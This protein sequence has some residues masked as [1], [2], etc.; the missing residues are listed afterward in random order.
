MKYSVLL[1]FL[2]ACGVAQ[3]NKSAAPAKPS[4][5]QAT[6]MDP[7]Y[8]TG[9][10]H[11][12]KYGNYNY[13]QAA[14]KSALD[15]IISEIKVNVQSSTTL[16]QL[17]VNKKF[18]EQY[19]QIIKT[20][21]ADELEEFEQADAWEDQ[22]NYW[23]YIRLSK[24]RYKQ[25]KEDKKRNAVTLGLDFFT[26]ARLAEQ[27]GDIV[28]SLSYY[29]QGFRAVEKYLAEP[30]RAEYQGQEILLSNEIIRS[31][32]QMMNKI[33]ISAEPKEISV[34]RRIIKSN[35]QVTAKARERGNNKAIAGLP[36]SAV[37]E[38]GSGN[39]FPSF[40]SDENGLA[41]V[42]ITQI[43]S[44]DAEQQIAIG[45]NPNAFENNDSSAVF[46][47]IAKKLVVPKA[48]VLLHV[49]RPLVY[50]T[51]SEK[52]L[53]AEKSS[54]ELTNAVTNYLTQSGFE[55]TDDSKKAEMAVDIS[56]DTE[57]GVQSGNIFITY[58]S[59]SIRVKS[60]PDGKEIYTSSLNRV[61]GYS[62]DFE[63][64]SQQAYAEGLKKLTHENLPQILS[65]ITQ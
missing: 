46:S 34:N 49:Q 23:V 32:Q 54:K 38:K 50:V 22:Q 25:I 2:F 5:L 12:L 33:E 62:L 8:Y 41:K 44:R 4:W 61:K 1:I 57:K 35:I 40:K 47:L 3:K 16:S 31:L 53:G 36:L 64:S 63:R 20:T 39:V 26:K 6:P 29:Y 18:Q 24:A 14:K 48:A 21:A 52:S 65:Y 43:S 30:I 51:A 45:V 28:T 60:L 15:D 42:L 10:G 11:S 55:I 58:L 17:D 37:F 9:I 56:S 7:D 59:G 19:E 13:I 27:S